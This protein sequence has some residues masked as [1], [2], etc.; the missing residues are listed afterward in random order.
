MSDQPSRSR[1]RF[2]W[3][4]GLAKL[5]RKFVCG[6]NGRGCLAIEPVDGKL[7][8]DIGI[9]VDAAMGVGDVRQKFYRKMLERGQPLL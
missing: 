2:A 1:G 8:R 4:R 6:V 5:C 9:G 7:K 3:L